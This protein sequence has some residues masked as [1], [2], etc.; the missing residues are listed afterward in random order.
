MSLWKRKKEPI[1]RIRTS[2]RADGRMI[3]SLAE[4]E[5]ALRAR[6]G[7]Y[8]P[9]PDKMP[10]GPVLSHQG[11][12]AQGAQITSCPLY[13]NLEWGKAAGFLTVLDNSRYL[14]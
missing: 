4:D 6:T 2:Y 13:M 3:I 5:E 9:D 14:N 8:T 12:C 1:L 11:I 7:S 10:G